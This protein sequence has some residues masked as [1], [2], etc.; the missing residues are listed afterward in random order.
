MFDAGLAEAGF[1]HPADA[2]G[3]GV[4]EAARGFDEH[5]EAHEKGGVVIAGATAPVVMRIH[6]FGIGPVPG[7]RGSAET[8][9]AT[10]GKE[11]GSG[12]IRV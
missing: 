2:V 6:L 8:L 12:A 11:M 1:F 4:V 5:V 9:Q 7:R 3:A 10:A